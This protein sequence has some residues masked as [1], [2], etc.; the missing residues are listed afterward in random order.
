MPV[1]HR[2]R[3]P[4]GA[5]L[6]EDLRADLGPGGRGASRPTPSTATSSCRKLIP[7]L[8]VEGAI[9]ARAGVAQ[10]PP[11]SRARGACPRSRR[12]R[13]DPRSSA[14]SST[15]RRRRSCGSCRA[16]PCRSA[17][18]AARAPR[19]RV[20]NE[21]TGPIRS[22]TSATSSAGIS[23]GSRST[24][25]LS[26]TNPIGTWPLRSSATPTTAHSATSGWLASTSSIAPVDSRWPAVLITS[27]MRL[28]TNT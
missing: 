4:R 8:L 19:S 12:A 21:A 18:W 28:I 17:S 23:S 14:A 9:G 2:R 10:A 3:H 27:S 16:A 24:P 11:R 6:Q 25:A 26:T 15:P 1:E 22:R 13:P 7:A 20:L 5:R